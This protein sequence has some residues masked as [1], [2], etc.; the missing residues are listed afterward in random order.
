MT[1]PTLPE[2]AQVVDHF[3]SGVGWIADTAETMQRASHALITEGAGADSSLWLT[4]PVD[5]DGLDELLAEYGTVAGVVVLLGRH[6]R[7][8]S[9]IARRHD[10]SVWAP[11][12]LSDVAGISTR[13]LSGSSPNSQ[14][15]ATSLT[16]STTGSGR[17][18]SSTMRTMAC[19]LSLRRLERPRTSGPATG[20]LECIRSSGSDHHRRCL[21]SNPTVFSWD[22]GAV[23]TAVQDHSLRTRSR[24]PADGCH[25]SPPRR[26]G[27]CFRKI[28]ASGRDRYSAA[29]L[30]RRVSDPTALTAT[31]LG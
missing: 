21:S 16:S 14:I 3:D 12:C 15:P 2:P 24:E 25:A 11:E 20:R 4:D 31:R 1:R 18:Q 19:S 22:T 5:T 6:T 7:D 29:E 28:S 9:V 30:F 23:C 26:S 8:A 17:K 10:V 27:Q 13:R